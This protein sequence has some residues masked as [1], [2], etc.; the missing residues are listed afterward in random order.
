MNDARRALR[1]EIAALEH[2]L[3]RVNDSLERNRT[4]AMEQRGR[5]LRANIALCRRDLEAAER[6]LQSDGNPP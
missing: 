4:H 2:E 1:Q 6:T 5:Q 3:R